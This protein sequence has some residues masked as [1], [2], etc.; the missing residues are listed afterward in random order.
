MR[1][2]VG[3]DCAVTIEVT[4]LSD[5]E[6]VHIKWLIREL[7]QAHQLRRDKRSI[8]AGA[9]APALT[10]IIFANIYLHKSDFTAEI[11]GPALITR[12]TRPLSSTFRNQYHIQNVHKPAAQR[13]R[14]KFQ[15]AAAGICRCKTSVKIV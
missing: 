7:L 2:S 11:I 3:P 6:I 9:H 15:I 1:L 13:H 10:F 5:D 14:S 12:S 8:S 4:G